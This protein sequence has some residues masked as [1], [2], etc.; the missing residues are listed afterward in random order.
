MMS[1]KINKGF[2]WTKKPIAADLERLKEEVEFFNQKMIKSLGTPKYEKNA[3]S[4]AITLSAFNS[5][6]RRFEKEKENKRK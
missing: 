5:I 6:K 4:H 1:Y 3:A 2:A